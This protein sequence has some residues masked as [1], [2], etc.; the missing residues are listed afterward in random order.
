MFL[1]IRL[2]LL[3][4]AITLAGFS[5]ENETQVNP[6]P[7][8]ETNVE[9][10]GKNI[11]NIVLGPYFPIA[12]GDNF[13]NNG[14]ETKTGARIAFKVNAYKGL[15]IGPYFSVF[16]A[17]VTDKNLLGNYRKT[18]NFTVGAIAGY[19]THINKFDLSLGVGVGASTYDN[20][21]YY[22]NF[23]DTA[24]SVWLNPEIAYR[25]IPYL[26]FYIAPEL[27]HDFMNIETPAELKDTFKGANYFNISVGLRI[28][29][30][31]AYK[32]L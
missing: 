32:Y 31:T 13:V 23:Q 14:M 16:N 22:D 3:A 24:T 2:F 29:L 28:N 25:V 19:E 7:E 4:F 18:T 21:G 8:A 11:G 6:N 26:S 30:G 12:F 9:R 15:Y 20:D 1:N 27:R 5:Q 10:T 17:E